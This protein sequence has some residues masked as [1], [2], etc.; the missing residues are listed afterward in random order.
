METLSELLKLAQGDRTQNQFAL[1]CG[2]GSSTLT[3]LMQGSRNPK[4]EILKKIAAKAYNGVT[5]DMLMRAAGF[6]EVQPEQ[7]QTFSP[8]EINLISD[9]RELN[10]VSKKLVRQMVETLK[11]TNAA[12]TDNRNKYRN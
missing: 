12:T 11:G 5:Y 10:P 9:Y 6:I 4:P 7:S 8:E 2:I 1:H 3:R